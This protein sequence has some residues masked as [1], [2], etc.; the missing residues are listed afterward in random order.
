MDSYRV[1]ARIPVGSEPTYPAVIIAS[2]RIYLPTHGDGQLVEVDG[3]SGRVVRRTYAGEGAFGLVI[4]ETLNRAYV[5]ARDLRTINSVDLASMQELSGQRITPGGVPFAL[6]F[7][8]A[9]HRLYVHSLVPGHTDS[10]GV[11]SAGQTGLTHLTTFLV[12]EG[13]NLMG[14]RLGIN[15]TANHVF[16]INTAAHSM[17]VID[18]ASNRPMTEIPLWME[19]FGVAVSRQSGKVYVGGRGQDDL[20]VLPDSF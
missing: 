1:L 6:G 14:G 11:F 18:G 20:W 9:T 12:A 3:E 17:T 8:P 7:N 13:G 15:S 4:N 10:I 19:V 5:S 2:N 16:V